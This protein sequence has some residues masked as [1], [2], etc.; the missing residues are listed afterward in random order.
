M[1]HRGSKVLIK[2]G[3]WAGM[4]GKVTRVLTGAGAPR[5]YEVRVDVHGVRVSL[6]ESSVELDM[7]A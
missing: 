1:I 7:L 5:R 3:L 6:A 2:R 4:R